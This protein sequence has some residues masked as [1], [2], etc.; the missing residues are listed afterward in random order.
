MKL[1]ASKTKNLIVS[2]FR[3]VDPLHL[4][5]SVSGSFINNSEQLTILGVSF[6]SKFNF[7][8][9]LKNVS[10]VVSRKIGILQNCF[11]IPR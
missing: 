5:V 4:L 9:H 1:N 2:R 7:I 6:A 3:T 11:Y 10:S 8:N